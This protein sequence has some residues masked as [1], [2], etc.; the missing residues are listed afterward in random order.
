MSSLTSKR[1]ILPVLLALL[2]L[3]LAAGFSASSVF[4]RPN[5]SSPAGTTVLAP[6]STANAFAHFN[7][8][9]GAPQS[10]GTVAPGTKFTLD[11]YINAGSNRDVTAAQS[12]LTFNPAVLQVVSPSGSSCNP[13]QTASPDITTFDAVLQNEICN[14][15]NPCDFR[16]MQVPGG[17]IAFASGALSNPQCTN[18]CGGDFRV[19][20]ITFCAANGGRANLHWEFAPSAPQTR[21]SEITV[22]SF[23]EVQNASLYH[24]YVINVSG[25]TATPGPPTWTPKPQFTP[26]PT[27][28]CNINFT[29]VN[30]GDVFYDEI[31]AMFCQQVIS[32]YSDHTFRPYD[33]TRRAQIAKIVV[34]G[35]GFPV[36]THGGPHFR[37][38]TTDNQFYPYVETAAN[39]N[40]VSGYSDGTFRPWDNVKRGQIAKI[41]IGAAQR[42]NGW[43]LA[44]PSSPSFSDVPKAN[45]F[46]GFIETAKTHNLIAG[47]ATN[48]FCVDDYAKRGQLCK[49]ISGALH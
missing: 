8:V 2:G 5:A 35:F 7:P 42:K 31:K 37:D 39:L 16:G 38:V 49:I 32:G 18:G 10:G 20:S 13:V 46:Y 30:Q 48:R 33:Y 14:G 17:R 45:V 43:A 25:A 27:G 15:P 19:A 3:G 24:D 41:V 40:L 12:F 9:N 28:G 47:C 29:D 11:L 6:S 36:D 22:L 1:P 44:N 26:T 4:A 21:D 23:D 34:L